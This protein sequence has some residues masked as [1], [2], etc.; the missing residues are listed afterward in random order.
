MGEKIFVAGATGAVGTALIPLLVEAGH[1]VYGGTRRADRA[2]ALEARG[3][4]PVVV[5][6]FDAPALRD[7]LVRIAPTV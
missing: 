1:A 5:D 2:A 3:V 6:A 4:M 7:A